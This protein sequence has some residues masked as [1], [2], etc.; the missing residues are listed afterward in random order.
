[1]K[2][3]KYKETFLAALLVIACFSCKKKEKA[4]DDG[5]VK[6]HWFSINQYA[7]DQ[8]NTFSGSPFVIIKTVKENGKIDSSYTNSDTI[9]W[10]P[11]FKVFAQTDISDAKY[12]DQYNYN[13]FPDNEEQA[14]LDLFYQAKDEEQF[15]QKLLVTI[16]QYTMKV[17]GIYIETYKKTAWSSC[18]QKLYYSP[19][20]KIQIQ[21]DERPVIG[22]KKY[23]IVEYNFMR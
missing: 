12:F 4:V 16:D 5:D 20:K 21:T 13:Y 7:L 9:S 1:M 17:K 10:A 18:T 23:T 11:I 6:K 3:F 22:S 19:M 14:T 2:H 8:W 15:T